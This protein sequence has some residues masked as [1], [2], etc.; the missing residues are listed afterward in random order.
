M[1]AT[2]VG[3]WRTIDDTTHQP[4]GLVRLFERDGEIFGTI[5]ASF[6]PKEAR[7]VC[8]KCEGDRKDKPLIGLLFLRHMKRH[9]DEYSGGDIVD[10]DTGWVYRCRLTLLDGGK[11]MVVRGFL[12]IALLG[13]S[14]VW[15]REE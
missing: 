3:V 15:L 1:D 8:S 9:G 4:R 12:G 6:D 5:E 10:P 11:K 7:L 14:Q 13:R 2:P